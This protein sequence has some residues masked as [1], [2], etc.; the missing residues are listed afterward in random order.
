[1]ASGESTIT[2]W[3]SAGGAELLPDASRRLVYVMVFRLGLVTLLLGLMI[4]MTLVGG[5]PLRLATL[6]AQVLFGVV[7]AAYVAALVFAVLVRRLHARRLFV[8][9]QIVLDVVLVSAL[10]H[11]TGGI[12]SAWTF[13]YPLAIVE[14]AVVALKPGALWTMMLTTGAF[15]GTAVGGFLGWIPIVADQSVLPWQISPEDLG[16]GLLVNL[17]A[18]I[19]VATLAAFLAD[20]LERASAQVAVQEEAIRDIRRLNAAILESLPLGVITL[21]SEERVVAVNPAASQLLGRDVRGG[22]YLDLAEGLPDLGSFRPRAGQVERR[23]TRLSESLGGRRVQVTVSSLMGDSEG[24]VGSIL[25]VEDQSEIEAMKER[26]AQA[27]RLAAVGRLAAGIA[28]EIRNPLSSVSGALE[29]LRSAPSL[30][31]EDQRLLEIALREVSRLEGLVSSLL[32]YARPRPPVPV[33]FDAAELILEVAAAAGRDPLF[34]QVEVTPR[35]EGDTHMEADPDQLRQVLWNLLRNGAEAMPEGGPLTVRVS[36]VVLGEPSEGPE[37]S[38]GSGAAGVGDRPGSSEGVARKTE[39]WVEI[40]VQD[41]GSGMDAAAQKNLFE[42]FFS[43][44]EKGTGLGLATVHRIVTEHGGRVE[45]ESAPGAGA[46]IRVLLPS[47]RPGWR[48]EQDG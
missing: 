21:D 38:G 35:F 9:S 46:T 7:A 24:E 29:M 16:R 27:E 1:M 19:A 5:V 25:V 11:L 45:V 14:A 31:A 41:Q 12:K 36:G 8:A 4:V 39:R 2:K 40:V 32:G 42:P 15:L 6:H 44:K 20:Q 33:P 47:A 26:V 34:E 48:G 28:H 13:L 17:A 3:L 43:T 22:S 23:P 10:V 18:Q 30:E 37:A